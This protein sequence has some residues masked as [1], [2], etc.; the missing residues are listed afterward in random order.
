MM[1][2]TA[3]TTERL[4]YATITRSSSAFVAPFFFFFF[5][6]LHYGLACVTVVAQ[7]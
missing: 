1:S 2:G 3:T 4:A 5:R 6:L 7:R